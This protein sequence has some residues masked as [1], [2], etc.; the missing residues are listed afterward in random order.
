MLIYS[1]CPFVLKSRKVLLKKNACKGAWEL[2]SSL[3]ATRTS[4]SC[5]HSQH[6]Q[7]K[8]LQFKQKLRVSSPQ[9]R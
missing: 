6:G 5:H 9:L 2:Q 8:T 4:K 1:F 7:E 3:D